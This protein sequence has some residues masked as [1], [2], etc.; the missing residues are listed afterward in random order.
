MS[1]GSL[2]PSYPVQFG[3]FLRSWIDDPLAVGAVAPSGPAL[4]KLMVSEVFPG[5]RVMELGPGTGTL[6]RAIINRGVSARDLYLLERSPRFT[7]LLK[8]E[9]CNVTVIEAD[10]TVRNHVLDELHASM[11]FVISGLPLVLFSPAQKRGLLQQCFEYLARAGSLYQF[12]YGVRCPI[13]RGLLAELGLEATRVGVA[14]LNV[15]PA[16]V[17]RIRR[18]G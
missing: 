18:R 1:V 17:Y 6:T 3:R 15:P 2:R 7:A 12:T 14:A 11:D 4:A 5:A 13:G 10:A 16:F 8:K 9:F